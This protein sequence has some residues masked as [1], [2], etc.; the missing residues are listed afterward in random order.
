MSEHAVNGGAESLD[1]GR[2]VRRAVEALEYLVL[3]LPLGLVC[4]ARP[5]RCSS[6]ARRSARSGSGCRSSCSW[7]PANGRL[8]EIERRQANRLLDAH[9]APLIPPT[10]HEGTL[11]RRAIDTLGDRD[12]WRVLV[13]VATKLPVAVVGLAAGLFPVA[14]TA[15]AAD[16]RR[17]AASAISA[18]ATTSARGRSGR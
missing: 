14:V 11:W 13:L 2:R 5:R 6:S 12:N 1:F 3:S 8:A 17:R 4:A 7:S 10:H 16:L 9:I 15:W 18:T